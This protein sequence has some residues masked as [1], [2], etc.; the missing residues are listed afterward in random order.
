MRHQLL[1]LAAF[2]GSPPRCLA[3]PQ[4]SERNVLLPPESEV[5]LS[6]QGGGPCLEW[7][8]DREDLASIVSSYCKEGISFATLR[9]GR[10]PQGLKRAFITAQ[11]ARGGGAG[12]GGEEGGEEATEPLIC[13][14]N[15]AEVQSLQI[16]TVTRRM[17]AQELQWLQVSALDG[18]GNAFSL[19]GVR[20]MRFEWSFS[21]VGA[22]VLRPPHSTRQQ[23][24]PELLTLSDSEAKRYFKIPV[25]ALPLPTGVEVR[26]Q[27]VHPSR[28]VVRREMVQI[29]NASLLIEPASLVVMAP[30]MGTQ[31]RLRYCPEL[32]ECHQPSQS[33]TLWSIHPSSVASINGSGYADALAVGPAHVRARVSL[34][35]A[36]VDLVVARP[37][38][39]D[40]TLLS[41]CSVDVSAKCVEWAEAGECDCNP[42]YMR[43]ECGGACCDQDGRPTIVVGDERLVSN[44]NAPSSLPR[45]SQLLSCSESKPPLTSSL[46]LISDELTLSSTLS[47]PL[48]SLNMSNV[49]SPYAQVKLSLMSEGEDAPMLLPSSSSSPPHLL[50]ALAHT[51]DA[52]ISLHPT[53][54]LRCGRSCSLDCPPHR[55][56]PTPD[57]GFVVRPTCVCAVL[58]ALKVGEENIRGSLAASPPTT[59]STI[60]WQ[61]LAAEL[62]VRVVAPLS[63]PTYPQ[64]FP[65]VCAAGAVLPSLPVIPLPSPSGGSGSLG[66]RL[67]SPTAANVSLSLSSSQLQLRQPS[68]V[69]LAAFDKEASGNAAC[70]EMETHEI[71]ALA[72][73]AQQEEDVLVGTN[74]TI[75]IGFKGTG[76][77][78][79]GLLRFDNCEDI[80]LTWQLASSSTASPPFLQRPLSPSVFSSLLTSGSA[81]CHAECPA[82]SSISCALIP[83]QANSPGSSTLSLLLTNRCSEDEAQLRA[84]VQLHAIEHLPPHPIN[85]CAS[86]PNSPVGQH[87]RLPLAIL[88]P[89]LRRAALEVS[90]S[91]ASSLR[92]DVAM[93]SALVARVVGSS[94]RERER[95]DV[96]L[97][98][99]CSTPHSQP[100]ELSAPLISTL[101]E[102]S[103]SSL[104]LLVLCASPP[105]FVD[106]FP[107][108]SSSPT[109]VVALGELLQLRVR[110]GWLAAELA[111]T[112]SFETSGRN[113]VLADDLQ[114]RVGK[115]R[116][117]SE[118]EGEG[119]GEG[120]SAE[121][122]VSV[123]PMHNGVLKLG[124]GLGPEFPSCATTPP[125]SL[126]VA[127]G[128]FAIKCPSTV[129]LPGET[130]RCY[131]LFSA[132]REPLAPTTDLLDLVSFNCAVICTSLLPVAF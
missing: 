129:M 86:P 82:D 62:P 78:N 65:H 89:P 6:V 17:V 24:D 60:A 5:E 81:I 126:V 64:V 130:M 92:L 43:A 3:A 80:Q 103:R 90:P 12:E 37:H 47:H 61:A 69:R 33:S 125:L 87:V 21:P 49:L 76:S 66:W 108:P 131:A 95:R 31:Y 118:R 94:S 44:A 18:D 36:E 41:E 59:S 132:G 91:R 53:S 42:S 74:F 57:D 20:T 70:M 107:S 115:T 99:T 119:W 68:R 124:L 67:A 123:R 8:S 34:M 96:E 71:I 79:R 45:S 13:E 58:R 16:L 2:L 28:H 25:R 117:L 32:A 1:A 114:L 105:A 98:L 122:E 46:V 7:S 19:L 39:L 104:Q 52:I 93:P 23:L 63:L 75:P 22:L 116:Y 51:G 14:V 4:I 9:T 73:R 121:W 10:A 84:S 102:A 101:V 97:L 54:P 56:C 120:E 26:A 77:G 83:L 112:A 15:V 88:S 72:I 127:L 111:A 100:V 11:A 110:G 29:L 109:P 27:L 40:V 48:P 113:S 128:G 55:P 30:G 85:L 35:R 38:A 50:P 106:P